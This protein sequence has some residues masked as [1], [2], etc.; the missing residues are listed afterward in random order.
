[1]LS[2]SCTIPDGFNRK[3]N[4]ERLVKKVHEHIEF[5][6]DNKLPNVIFFSGNRRGMSDEEGLA[7]CARRAQTGRRLRGEEET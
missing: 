5:A 2:G 4:H 6:A 1:M 3:E 7:N